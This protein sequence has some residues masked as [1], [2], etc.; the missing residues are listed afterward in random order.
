MTRWEVLRSM[1]EQNGW[2]SGCELGVFKG[3]TFFYLL[4]HCVDLRMVGVDRWE[5]TPGPTQDRETGFASYEDHPMGQYAKDVKF[6]AKA[7]GT[8]AWIFH[9]LTTKIADYFND[10]VFDFVFVDASHDTESV[11]ADITAWRSKIKPEGLLI[12]HDINWPSVQRALQSLEI[13]WSEADAHIWY[14]KP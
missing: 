13:K 5:R 7:Y 10:G 2:V 1:V 8:R 4:D 6:K 9:D 3:E 11:I 12:G 14:C